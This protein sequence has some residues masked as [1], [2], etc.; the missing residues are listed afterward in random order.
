MDAQTSTCR[1]GWYGR[2][3]HVVDDRDPG[4]LQRLRVFKVG[5]SVAVVDGAGVD[6]GCV[7]G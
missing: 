7:F 2:I 6:D 3:V 5:G 1:L 4:A